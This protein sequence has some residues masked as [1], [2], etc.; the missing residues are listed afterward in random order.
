MSAACPHCGGSVTLAPAD[1]AE[2]ALLPVARPTMVQRRRDGLH[3]QAWGV[4]SLDELA[5][6]A[7]VMVEARSGKR[8]RATIGERCGAGTSG[9]HLYSLAGQRWTEAPEPDGGF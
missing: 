2:D 5:A 6:G 3:E 4:W 7:T 1:Q 9:G 8:W